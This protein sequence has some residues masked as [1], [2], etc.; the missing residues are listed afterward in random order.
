MLQM[1][2]LRPREAECLPQAIPESEETSGFPKS[3]MGS[4][5][6]VHLLLGWCISGLPMGVQEAHSTWLPLYH[7]TWYSP[8]VTATICHEVKLC[9]RAGQESTFCAGSSL[10]QKHYIPELGCPCADLVNREQPDLSFTV[11]GL[12]LWVCPLPGCQKRLHRN[13]LLHEPQ[14]RC[15]LRPKEEEISKCIH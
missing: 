12:V 2:T 7:P 5:T 14:F 11:I 6:P 13:V 9:Q 4:L 10:V 1:R 15:R 3:L 8:G